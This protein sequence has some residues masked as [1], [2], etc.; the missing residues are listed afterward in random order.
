MMRWMPGALCLT[1]TV[2]ALG[3]SSDELGSC[4]TTSDCLE[5][6][7]CVSGRCTTENGAD[8]G[9]AV[10]D[11]GG[12]RDAEPPAPTITSLA[13][14][15]PSV[16]LVASNGARPTA[17]F[18]VVARYSDGSRRELPGGR[19]TVSPY[20]LGS[21]D[22]VGHFVADGRFGGEG[23]VEVEAEGHTARARVRIRLETVVL[24]EGVTADVPPRFAIQAVDD[25]AREATIVYPL[26]GAVMPQNVYPADI[27]WQSSSRGDLYRV[28]IEKPN[29]SLTGYVLAGADFRSGWLADEVGWRRVAQSDAA[30]PASIRVDRL[31][32]SSG[33]LILGKP[34]EVRFARAALTGSVYYWDIVAG[35]IIRI[36]DGTA[37]RQAFMPSP[38]LGCVGCHSVSTSGRYMAGRFGG[39]ENVGSV[40]DLTKDLTPDPPPLEFPT[41]ESMRWWFSSWSPDDARLVV[42]LTEESPSTAGLAFVDPKSGTYVSPLEGALPTGRATH[43]AWSPDGTEIAYVGNLD[44]W[45]GGNTT[46]DIHIL[47][48]LGLDRVGSSRLL[49][50]GEQIPGAVPA[51]RAASYPSYS[52]DSRWVAFAHGTSSRSEN[53]ESALYIVR[54]DGTGLVRLSKASGGPDAVTSFQ[55][56]FSP[57]EQDGYYWLSFL[58]RRDYGNPSSGTA[59]TGRQQI[60]VAAIKTNP[61]PGEDPSAVPYWLPGQ[62]TDSLNISAYWA[63]RPCREGGA[64]CAVGAECC[65]DV[66]NVD[67]AGGAI[68]TD[69]PSGE[70]SEFGRACSGPGD[71]CAGLPCAGGICGAL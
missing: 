29:A 66:C 21:I 50:A 65:S 52:P 4:N 11:A 18:T 19:F 5:G 26:H 15:P 69:P 32:A 63:P 28:S 22:T 14:E 13:L 58:S 42:S 24:G 64:S 25:P 7:T 54:R 2:A 37:N 48:M 51:G 9:L 45:G 31:E 57:F 56:R 62:S 6:T 3:C 16:E 36:D 43:P 33:D 46:G 70:C 53:G 55:P 1:A 12:A 8:G 20:A 10:D 47:E 59:G 35:R 23:E 68:C 40:F 34:V 60:W 49:V 17:D 39:G 30:S 61:Q 67:N 44:A 38:P 41:N 27:Q 71:C